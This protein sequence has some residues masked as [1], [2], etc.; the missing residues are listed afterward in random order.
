MTDKHPISQG[1]ESE[2]T[3]CWREHNPGYVCILPEGHAE[4]EDRDAAV[5]AA[6]AAIKP[7]GTWPMAVNAVEAAR[8]VIIR[9]EHQRLLDWMHLELDAG[10][11]PQEVFGIMNVALRWSV[12]KARR[13]VV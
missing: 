5:V 4:G 8:P 7:F 9:E 11:T 10:R 1:M 6:Y 12:E 3:L 13:W 2:H